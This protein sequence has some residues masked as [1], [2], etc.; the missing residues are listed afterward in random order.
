MLLFFVHQEVCEEAG[1][2]WSKGFDSFHVT[3]EYLDSQLSK[4]SV[5]LGSRKIVDPQKLLEHKLQSLKSFRTLN[6]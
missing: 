4:V 5:N 1:L 3:F 2:G 6:I